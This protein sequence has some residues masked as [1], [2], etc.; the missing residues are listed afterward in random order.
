ME[1]L[2]EELKFSRSSNYRPFVVAAPSTNIAQPTA[3]IKATIT[4]CFTCSKRSPFWKVSRGNCQQL[5]QVNR[6]RQLFPDRRMTGRC[7]TPPCA[8]SFRPSSRTPN[9]NK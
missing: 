1:Y 2:F 4:F 8:V 6:S 5:E 7:D 9:M 3:T